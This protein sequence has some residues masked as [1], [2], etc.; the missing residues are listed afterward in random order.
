MWIGLNVYVT[1]VKEK[2]NMN[3]ETVDG[4]NGEEM[5]RKKGKGEMINYVMVELKNKSLKI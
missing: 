5:G 3:W 2:E 1:M 4:T